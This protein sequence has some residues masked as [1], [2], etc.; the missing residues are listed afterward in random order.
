MGKVGGTMFHGPVLHSVRHS[1]G[2]FIIQAAAFVDR[3]FQRGVDFI[4]N[5]ILF[6]ITQ[7]YMNTGTAKC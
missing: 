3:L 6:S 5:T 1:I 7:G 2:H 4:G